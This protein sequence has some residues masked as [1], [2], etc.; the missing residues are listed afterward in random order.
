MGKEIPWEIRERAEELYVV[1]AMTYDQVAKS[2]GVS[3]S[4]L[5]R[6][7]KDGAWTE[8]KREY[9]KALADIKRN[10]VLLRQNL[11]RNALGSLD[12]QDVYAAAR[13]EMVAKA[14]KKESQDITP[15]SDTVEINTP[16]EAVHALGEAMERKINLMMHGNIDLAGVK[17]VHQCLELLEKMKARYAP[18]DNASAKKGGLSEA[19]ANNIRAKIMGIIK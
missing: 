7:A 6:W 17:Q 3:L 11:I 2:T 4:Q 13:F 16:Q 12:P 19:A 15:I 5:K 14:G 9:R 1:D 18:E 8:K 10:S